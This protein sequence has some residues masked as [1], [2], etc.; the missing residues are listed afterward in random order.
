[1]DSIFAPIDIYNNRRL[2]IVIPGRDFYETPLTGRIPVIDAKVHRKVE[3]LFRNAVF[4]DKKTNSRPL[5]LKPDIAP[6]V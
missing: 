5:R 2:F 4:S 6:D 1:E 3:Q